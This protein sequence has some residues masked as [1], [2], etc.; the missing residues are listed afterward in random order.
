MR[1]IS[2]ESL[3]AHGRAYRFGATAVSVLA[4]A[5]FMPQ[6]A[7]AQ[8][9]A[10]AG[11]AK[12]ADVIIVTGIRHGIEEAIT[13]KRNSLAI[14]ESVSAEDIGK[15]PNVSI[16]ETLAQIPGLAAQRVNGQAEIVSIRGFSPDFT[17]TLLNGRPQASSGYNRAVEFDQ[18][19]AELIARVDVYKTP[20]LDLAGMGLSGTTNMQTVRPLAYGKQVFAV[21]MLVNSKVGDTFSFPEIAAWLT[22]A[23]FENVRTLEA[24]GPSPLILANRAR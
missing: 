23:G 6:V 20:N 8:D 13:A 17:T 1:I 7:L 12:P 18:Y 2:R 24:P 9:S 14:I 21:N 10:P 16:A 11:E 22:Q 19:P 15:L 4:L 5:A 3:N